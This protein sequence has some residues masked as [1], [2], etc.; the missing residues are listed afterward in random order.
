[1]EATNFLYRGLKFIYL[2]GKNNRSSVGGARKF[3]SH[4]IIH[5]FREP[6]DDAQPICYRVYLKP[7][8][9]TSKI[10]KQFSSNYEKFNN[11]LS[12]KEQ[13]KRQKEWQAVRVVRPAAAERRW[14]FALEHVC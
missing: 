13:K 7:H 1:M 9:S 10:Q 11:Y 5:F 6:N 2:D 3:P 12:A 8:L 4:F 14:Q